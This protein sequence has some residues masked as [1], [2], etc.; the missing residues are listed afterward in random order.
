MFCVTQWLLCVSLC[1][2]NSDSRLPIHK[3]GIMP[4][5][6]QYRISFRFVYPVLY[7]RRKKIANLSAI[8]ITNRNKNKERNISFFG[9]KYLITF[10]AE[11]NIENNGEYRT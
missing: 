5:D 2:S 3:F 7:R 10:E 8:L 11:N 4:I 1:Y 6:N 9:L